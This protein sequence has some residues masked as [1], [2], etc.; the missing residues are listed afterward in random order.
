MPTYQTHRSHVDLFSYFFVMY[1]LT[2][3][4]EQRKAITKERNHKI[5]GGYCRISSGSFV[6]NIVVNEVNTWKCL[7]LDS[8]WVLQVVEMS[9]MHFVVH[10]LPGTEDQLIDRWVTIDHDYQT[11]FNIVKFLLCRTLMFST[12]LL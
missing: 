10:P 8:L 5:N 2:C 3:I 11:P 9:S 7:S 6:P 1:R 12:S 4:W